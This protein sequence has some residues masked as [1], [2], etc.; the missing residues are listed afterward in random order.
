MLTTTH[1]KVIEYAENL[2][3]EAAEAA[4]RGKCLEKAVSL[5]DKQRVFVED[6]PEDLF[7]LRSPAIYRETRRCIDS[8]TLTPMRASNIVAHI[9]VEEAVKLASN[10]ENAVPALADTTYRWSG[11]P[12]EL[13]AN[14]GG[15]VYA[16]KVYNAPSRSIVECPKC[17]NTFEEITYIPS[18][19]LSALPNPPP[20]SIIRCPKCGFMGFP[21]FLSP[22]PRDLSLEI[23]KSEELFTIKDEESLITVVELIVVPYDAKEDPSRWVR[24][25]IEGE[26]VRHVMSPGT[27]DEIYVEGYPLHLWWAWDPHT[28]WITE[29]LR[30]ASL[31]HRSISLSIPSLAATTVFYMEKGSRKNDTYSEVKNMFYEEIRMAIRRKIEKHIWV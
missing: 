2:I 25:V 14:I 9:I 8:E 13:P 29:E 27:W 26:L 7:L 15:I 21:D 17:G 10:N 19:Y 12:Y 6:A 20:L 30:L 28:A 18:P 1:A 16:S 4:Y 22:I 3:N 11:D 5:A 31:I 24:V 23:V